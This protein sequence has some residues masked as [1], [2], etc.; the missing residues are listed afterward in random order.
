M[1]EGERVATD[2][3][4]KRKGEVPM[5]RAIGRGIFIGRSEVRVT[6]AELLGDDRVRIVVEA[7][8]RYA[9]SGP[10]V[11]LVQHL[12]RQQDLDHR[13]PEGQDLT[14]FELAMGQSIIIG[15]AVRIRNDGIDQNQ[16]AVLSVHAPDNVTVTRDEYSIADHRARQL[17]RD[18]GERAQV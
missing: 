8:M 17:K 2:V 11:T 12:A 16:R 13:P 3:G 10:E 14:E 4:S 6:V 5:W 1:K 7:Q 15:R 9:V 18:P